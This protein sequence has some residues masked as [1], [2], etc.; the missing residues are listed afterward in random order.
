LF[1][2]DSTSE[3]IIALAGSSLEFF[4]KD[5]LHNKIGSEKKIAQPFTLIIE[6]ESKGKKIV[7]EKKGE[8]VVTF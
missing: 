4:K 1:L 6:A 2:A 8:F 5:S 3:Y 7:S